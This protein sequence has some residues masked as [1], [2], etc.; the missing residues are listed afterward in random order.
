LV[1]SRQVLLLGDILV[2]E[3]AENADT[4]T[5]AA[6]VGKTKGSRETLILAGIVVLQVD[7]EVNGF[8]E[9]ALLAVGEDGLDRL[10]ELLWWNLGH[11]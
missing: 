9:L 2:D 1:L 4:H 10:S 5:R 6:D 3:V 8:L 11:F 7:L